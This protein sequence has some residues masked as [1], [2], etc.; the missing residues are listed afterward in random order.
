MNIS[1][2]LNVSPLHEEYRETLSEAFVVVI[3]TSELR[4]VKYY[5]ELVVSMTSITIYNEMLAHLCQ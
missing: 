2:D 3:D 1:S 4:A 5:Y